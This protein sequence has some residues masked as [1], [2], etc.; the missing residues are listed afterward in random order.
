MNFF[1][2][3][4]KPMNLKKA[5]LSICLAVMLIGGGGF[6][7]FR[8]FTGK[9][10]P[11]ATILPAVPVVAATV[12]RGDVPIYLRGLG[13]VIAYNT[14]TVR[15]QIQ[16]QLTQIAFTEGQTVH[17]GDLL[18][19]IDPAPYEAQL[20]Q[21][22]A[23][24]DRDAAQLKNAR[25]NLERYLPLLA[26]GFATPQL[27][28][29]QKAQ[30]AQLEAAVKSDEALIESARVQLG[31]TRLTSPINGVTGI[32]QIDQGNIIHPTDPSGLVV[33]TQLQPI[34]V[35]FTLPEADL[36]E[37]QQKMAQGQLTV[38]AFD[39]AD[40]IELDKGT[41]GLINNQINQ[42]SGTIQLKATFPNVSHRLWPGELVSARLLLD[43]LHDAITVAAPVVQRGPAGAYA[44]VIK[45][46]DTVEQR[47]ITVAQV[48]ENQA[49]V[50]AGLDTGDDVVVDGQSRLQPG[51]RVAIAQGAAAQQLAGA[52]APGVGIP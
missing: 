41:L 49:L 4:V 50:S 42:T 3:L 48:D 40:K 10:A 38:F 32:R 14:V 52:S 22:T 6:V 12:Q 36:P 17:V 2:F 46:D 21:M 33:V 31:Y 15:S 9:A 8:I 51:V 37:I 19:Q 44:Y 20:D 28:D 30:V 24:R 25:A 35:L 13:S 27:V 11:P 39:Q 34:S 29:T 26:N 18:A 1:L 23:N 43:T 7:Y 16:G 5:G 47:P 45:P